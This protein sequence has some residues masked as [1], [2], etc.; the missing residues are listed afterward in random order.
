MIISRCRFESHQDLIKQTNKNSECCLVWNCF[1]CS[2]FS[3]KY[4]CIHTNSTIW[5]RSPIR[6]HASST[7]VQLIM[8]LS[9]FAITPYFY[10]ILR[11]FF[12]FLNSQRSYFGFLRY[13][14][15]IFVILRSAKYF[16]LT[17]DLSNAKCGIFYEMKNGMVFWSCI[18]FDFDPLYFTLFFGWYFCASFLPHYT[19]ICQ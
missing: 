19:C 15:E 3:H 8:Q 7:N 6:L 14:S 11:C 16:T 9:H 4:P 18:G 10:G 2:H 17:Q 12:F 5:H 1:F 13:T